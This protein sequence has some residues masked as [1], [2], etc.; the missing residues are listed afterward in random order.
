M[1]YIKV[2]I[3]NYFPQNDHFKDV[4]KA[5]KQIWLHFS[6]FYWQQTTVEYNRIRAILK[7]LF[8]LIVG[9]ADKQLIYQAML[10]LLEG[11]VLSKRE[12]VIYIS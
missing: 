6:D 3:W 10:S 12:I 2:N 8:R 11:T 5:V 1:R 4:W 7:A 9:P